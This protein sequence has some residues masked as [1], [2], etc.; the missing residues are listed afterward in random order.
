MPALVSLREC[1][2]EEATPLLLQGLEQIPFVIR[3]LSCAGLGIKR[4]PEGQRAL[5]RV[6]L[7]DGDAN[8]RAEAANAL[9]SYGV[10]QTWPVL[11]RVFA[12]D[13]QWLVRCSILAALAEQPEMSPSR[14]LDLARLALDDADG[15]VR[16]GGAE[17]LGR[18]LLEAQEPHDAVT[19]EAREVMTALQRDGD[20]RVVAVALNSLPGFGTHPAARSE[21]D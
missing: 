18:I 11:R 21:T 5:E 1:T 7:E 8:V 2:V 3:S 4:S 17:L 9:A 16:V 19:R 10:E 20:H 15:T 13:G 12:A 14:L 6:L